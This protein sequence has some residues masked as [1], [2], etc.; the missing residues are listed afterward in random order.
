MAGI[1]QSQEKLFDGHVEGKQQAFDEHAINI[2]NSL[3][4]EAVLFGGEVRIR[5]PGNKSCV[6]VDN[7]HLDKLHM[8]ECKGKDI[9]NQTFVLERR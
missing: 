2:K 6:D 5:N 1:R 8:V 3:L 7:Y 4:K 9:W